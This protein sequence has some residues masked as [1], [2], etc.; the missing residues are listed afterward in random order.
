MKRL[1]TLVAAL[2]GAAALAAT[3]AAPAQV[4]GRDAVVMAMALEPTGLDPTTAA[5]ASIGEIV[6]Y[7]VLETLVKIREDG[8][9]VP[10]LV[11]KWTVSPDARTFTFEL[12]RGV[13]FHNGEPFDANTVKYSLE[14]A[15]A[16]DST[17]KDKQTFTNIE[18][19][20]VTDPHVVA[21]R[22]KAN[23]PD[24]LFN[25]GLST[26]VIVEPK[27]AATNATTP[28]GT[29]PY[30]IESW[31]KGSS[32]TMVK[33]PEYRD[34]AKI[35]MSRVTWRFISDPAAQIAAVLAG[36]IDAM[37][38][39][40]AKA[41]DAVKGD[42]RFVVQVGGSRAKTILAINNKKKPLDDVRVR[43]AIA[44]AIDRKAVVSGAADGFGVPIG[45]H[46][47]PGAFGFVDTTGINPFDPAK[48]RA[49]LAEAGVKTPLELSLKLPPPPYARQGGE[50]IAA[51]LAKVGIVAKIQNVEWAQWMSGVYTNRDYD[52][53]IISHVEPLDL[54][55]Y[56]KDN[57]YWNYESPKFRTLFSKISATGD[58]A[59]RA[60]LLG[61]A[62][63]L[64]AQESPNAFLYQP[65][66]VSVANAKLKGLW[67]DVPIFANDLSALHW[68]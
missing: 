8:S 65:Q 1:K 29:G 51:Q 60:K 36:D 41:I 30:R 17:N 18:A 37:P 14:R 34:A 19:I 3:V 35:R 58:D 2:V 24:F 45:S 67:K 39:I 27:S 4:R 25:M 16:A 38:R 7:N 10:L 59:E 5:A 44:M 61:E 50:V 48:A 13:R 20:R 49:L 22:L 32:L 26:A 62:Q 55:N 57:Y 47:V 52:L 11:E 56:A 9:T 28:V 43:R 53:T 6:H 42:P 66:W 33:W 40:T 64:I 12:R 46:Y 21:V 15:A 63:R 23:N 68:Q 54:G 31:Q